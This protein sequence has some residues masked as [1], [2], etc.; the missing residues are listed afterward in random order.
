MHRRSPALAA[1]AAVVLA[2]SCGGAGDREGADVAVPSTA[3][4]TTTAPVATASTL[5]AR[6]DWLGT[7]VLP[8]RP[9]GFGE[10]QPTPPEL[11]DRR[12]ATVD[13]LP[14][15]AGD[16]FESVVVAVPDAVRDRSTWSVGCPVTI[17]ELR[18][19]TVAFWGFDGEAHTG[20]LL[21]HRDVA[22]TVVDA[23]RRLHAERFPIEEMRVT[24]ADELDAPPTG[25]GNNTGAFVC[26]PSRGTTR[27]SD[28]A[29]GRAVDINPFHNPYV[30]DDVVL[31]EL[32]SAYVD[33]EWVR[34]GMLLAG[35]PA[36]AAF[37]A[38]GWGWGGAW[39]SAK[40]YMHMSESGR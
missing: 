31:P 16:A 3:S 28:H 25:D 20:E 21:V 12:F 9:D 39:R 29:L 36:V 24:R 33:R 23:F 26:R 14:P 2:A 35:S 37:T 5:P 18:Y 27:W 38:A 1:L 22:A 32:A 19:V 8:R 34:P 11:R 30:K 6:P 40:D 15:P 13:N 17:D 7:R 10:I 4:T